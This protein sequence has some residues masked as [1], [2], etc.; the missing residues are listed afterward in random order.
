MKKLLNF[1][2]EMLFSVMVA[3]IFSLFA[4]DFS[5]WLIVIFLGLIIWHHVTESRL[6]Q[7]LNPE[8][9]KGLDLINLETFSQTIAYYRNKNKKRSLKTYAYYQNLIKISNFYPMPLLFA[10]RM[11]QFRGAT[12]LPKKCLIFIGIKKLKKIF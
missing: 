4:L 9:K 8:S 5:T 10:K 7:S 12:N 2:T 1:L 11:A 3:F 6:L